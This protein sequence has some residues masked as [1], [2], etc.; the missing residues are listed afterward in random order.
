MQ[1]AWKKLTCLL[2]LMLTLGSTVAVS[3]EQSNDDEQQAADAQL[4][5]R[6]SEQH[7]KLVPIVA[8][9]DMFFGCNRERHSDPYDHQIAD[10]INEM[11]KDLLA[12]KLIHC[13][14]GDTLQSDVAVNFGL[15]GCFHAQMNELTPV[16]YQEK[17]AQMKHLLTVL[18]RE[19]RQK[20]LTQCVTD[21]AIYFLR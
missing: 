9:A 19:E 14:A 1:Q 6:F 20:S 21:Q 7:Q 8:V 16:Q 17:M 2:A 18:S 3:G 12:Q 11:D 15:L 5:A 10:L 4:R 13:L